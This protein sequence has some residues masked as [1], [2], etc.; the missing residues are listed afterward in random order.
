ME[1]SELVQACVGGLV[2]LLPLRYLLQAGV[3][4]SCYMFAVA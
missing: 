2:Y 4:S 3:M 1:P